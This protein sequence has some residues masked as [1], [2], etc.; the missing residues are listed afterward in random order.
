MKSR[1]FVVRLRS[2]S[3]SEGQY[4]SR[5]GLVAAV[6]LAALPPVHQIPV[7]Q[8]VYPRDS[9]VWQIRNHAKARSHRPRERGLWIHPYAGQPLIKSTTPF[10]VGQNLGGFARGAPLNSTML[11]TD[12]HA[13]SRKQLDR[14]HAHARQRRAHRTRSRVFCATAP[15]PTHGRISPGRVFYFP[16]Y[17]IS[18]AAF[19]GVNGTEGRIWHYFLGSCASIGCVVTRA[20]STI[21][22]NKIPKQW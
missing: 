4:P 14:A 7:R 16:L 18:L 8:F 15:A 20:A 22:Q 21:S 5:L 17:L 10:R 13:R 9:E 3:G 11:E 12:C 19:D 1:G 2:H 6:E